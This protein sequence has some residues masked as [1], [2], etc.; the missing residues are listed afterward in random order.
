[1]LGN[2]GNNENGITRES[3][4]RKGKCRNL[5]F[6]RSLSSVFAG[7][8]KSVPGPQSATTYE[9]IMTLNCEIA[10]KSNNFTHYCF[11]INISQKIPKMKKVL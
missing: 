5:H 1:M 8:N 6:E 3:G 9:I 11:I 7:N 4:K 10:E 2:D